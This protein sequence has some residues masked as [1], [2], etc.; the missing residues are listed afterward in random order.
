MSLAPSSAAPST[1]SGARFMAAF[2]DIERHIK[3][4]LYG[5]QDGAPGFRRAVDEFVKKRPKEL[6]PRQRESLLTFADLRNTLVHN[7]YF[8]G[9]PIAEPSEEV[10]EAIERLRDELL[11]PATVLNILRGKKPELVHPYTPVGETLLL[12]YANDYS[13]MPV[14]D[15][16]TYVGLL[17]T[18]TVARWVADQMRQHEGLAEDAPVEAVLSFA[19][20]DEQVFHVPRTLSV[21]ETLWRFATSAEAGKPVTALIITE[22]GKQNETP[23]G[24]VVAENLARLSD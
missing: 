17:T 4:S 9:K 13:Q 18:N 11:R 2:N 15:G 22:T 24:I 3:R 5:G 1:S 21:A 12:M 16:N 14:Y 6:R 7:P 19:E 10:T 23:L 8:D 20:G